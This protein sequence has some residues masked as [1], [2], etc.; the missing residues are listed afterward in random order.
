[1]LIFRRPRLTQQVFDRVRAAQPSVLIVV[2]DGPR[3]ANPQEDALVRET[4]EI[5]ATVDWECRVHRIYSD[6]N[7]GLKNRVS[8]GLDRVF[9]LVDSAIVL[10][11]DCVPSASFFPYATELLEKYRDDVRVGT[12]A[13]TSRVRGHMPSRFSYDFSADLR[14]WG[15]AT[16]ARTWH[17]FSAS[18]DLTRRLEVDE[19]DEVLSSLTGRRRRSVARMLRGSHALDSWAL[20]FLAHVIARKYVH[21]VPEVNLVENVGFGGEST[22]TKFESFV[23]QVPAGDM[24]FPLCHPL[25]VAENPA[26]DTVE[27][28]QDTLFA[29]SYI[30]CNPAEVLGRFIRYLRAR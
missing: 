29:W 12:I 8:S 20:P 27:E 10:E 30:I 2:A 13:A 4:R 14:I 25:E 26:V 19:Q 23:E 24:M 3:E 7:L 28:R 5:V 22:H 18:G 9:E 21:A 16:W 17:E 1:M 6:S 11:D 15:W